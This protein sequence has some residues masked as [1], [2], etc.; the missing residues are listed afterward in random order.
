MEIT[1]ISMKDYFKE[2]EFV[3]DRLQFDYLGGRYRGRGIMTWK[4]EQGFHIEAP[5][6]L[7][8]MPHSED[9][10]FGRVGV[11][12][13]SHQS[14][15][16]MALHNSNNRAIAP[17]VILV[18]R[19]DVINEKRISVNLNRVIFLKSFSKDLT[20]K[21]LTGS[22]LYEAH[23][24]NFLFDKMIYE[25]KLQFQNY[26]PLKKTV[27]SHSGFRYEG[28]KGQLVQGHLV[29]DRYLEFTW[30]LPREN[31]TKAYSWQLSEAIQHSLSILFGQGIN[32]LRREV[33]C[34]KLKRIEIRQQQSVNSLELLSPFS[35]RSELNR[36]EY[37]VRLTDFIVNNEPKSDVCCKILQ[38]LVDASHQKNWQVKELLVATTLE[39]ALR[40]IDNEP[41]QI[42]KSKWNVGNSLRKFLKYYL[43]EEWSEVYD[44]VMKAHTYLRD[45]NAHPDWLFTQ[46]GALSEEELK[47]SL[48]SMIFLSRFY[49]YMILALAGF[50]N[51]EP[52]FPKPHSKWNPVLI[53]A[54]TNL[55]GETQASE[56]HSTEQSNNSWQ[57]LLDSL[58]R[59]SDDFMETRKQ[60]PIQ[61]RE[62]LFE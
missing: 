17:S 57:S 1:E 28:E 26:G 38:Q 16:H 20:S 30:E 2:T 47:R 61:T 51:L 18:D 33:S 45:R 27:K 7:Q 32:L 25:E 22:A 31:F 56:M 36:K 23:N 13:K 43:S 12:R 46:G 29:D 58:D 55:N 54:P 8:D 48:D 37:F 3:L 10:E 40:N 60:P 15:I 21:F 44:S 6:D 14:S 9:V 19:F 24:I 35:N 34:S 49:G 5:L 41:F 52:Y 4:P 59:F 39:A 50:K 11:I 42:R 53:I 62:N